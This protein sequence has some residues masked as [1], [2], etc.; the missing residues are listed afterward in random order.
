MSNVFGVILK[1]GTLLYLFPKIG[2]P[3][4]NVSNKSNSFTKTASRQQMY[5]GKDR[6]VKQWDFSWSPAFVFGEMVV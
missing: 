5:P 2:F 4:E 3:F 1:T 6:L